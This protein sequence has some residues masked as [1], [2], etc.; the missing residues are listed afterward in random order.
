MRD[1]EGYTDDIYDQDYDLGFL[2]LHLLFTIPEKSGDLYF[3]VETYF[4]S[5]I[6]QLCSL[7]S[8]PLAYIEVN[9]NDSDDP[10]KYQ[11][12]YD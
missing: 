7:L 5:M 3:S 2:F 12:Y 11:Y 6:P 8:Y 10:I 9:I 1:D 4:Q